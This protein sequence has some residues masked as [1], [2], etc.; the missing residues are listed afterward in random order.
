MDSVTLLCTVVQKS[1]KPKELCHR[2]R[3]YAA[4]VYAVENLSGGIFFS[5]LAFL[6]DMYLNSRNAAV[7]HCEM[8]CK[9]YFGR[10]IPNEISTF[11]KKEDL[12]IMQPHTNFISLRRR[13]SVRCIYFLKFDHCLSRMTGVHAE[14][15]EFLTYAAASHR[16]EQ[17]FWQP[18]FKLSEIGFNDFYSL[19]LPLLHTLFL[20]TVYLCYGRVLSEHQSF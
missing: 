11:L 20:L 9:P 18:H 2:R 3:H 1:L 19:W 6:L 17:I 4:R 15:K 12:N 7:Y 13:F 16:G 5:F 14:V 8:W 10:L